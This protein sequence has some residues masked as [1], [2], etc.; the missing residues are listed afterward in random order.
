LKRVAATPRR[1][2][3]ECDRGVVATFKKSGN[4][5][6]F[7]PL[8]FRPDYSPTVMKH[9]FFG[10]TSSTS[11]QSDTRRKFHESTR[12]AA[13]PDGRLGFGCAEG[14]AEISPG[15]VRWCAVRKHLPW[16]NVPQNKFLRPWEREKVAAGRMRGV[17]EKHS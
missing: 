5:T 7:P 6:R 14:A 2:K 15:L 12:M 13:K 10:G 9:G 8:D 4:H 1:R 16:E 17:G 3:Y 11:P